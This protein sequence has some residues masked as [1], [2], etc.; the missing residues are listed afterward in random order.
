MAEGVEYLIA[1]IGDCRNAREGEFVFF[2]A[3]SKDHAGR[4]TDLRP[5]RGPPPSVR[6]DQRGL[7]S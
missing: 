1:W 4:A 2:R 3:C 6:P 7:H 5:E